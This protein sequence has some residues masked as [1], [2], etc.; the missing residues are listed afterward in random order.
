ME[1][2]FLCHV[3][4]GNNVAFAFDLR[5]GIFFLS[6][7]VVCYNVAFLFDS[8]KGIFVFMLYCW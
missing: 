8:W 2:L 6:R 7:L 4:V 5:K 3:V 1:C